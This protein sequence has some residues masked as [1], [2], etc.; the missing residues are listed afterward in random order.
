MKRNILAAATLAASLFG[1][2]AFA[3]ATIHTGSQVKPGNYVL[4]PSHTRVLFSTT[5][6][7]FTT[8]YGEFTNTTGTLKLD[9]INPAA[10]A[11]SV[12]IRTNSVSTSNT[13][14]DGELVEWFDATTYPTIAF[15]STSVAPTGPNTADVTGNLTFHGVTK[16]VTLSVSFNGAGTNPMDK[17]YTA[18]FEVSGDLKRADFGVTKDEPFIGDDVKLI[19]SAAFEHE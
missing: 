10:S 12:V 1:S 8:W 9:P 13:R 18:G 2:Q 7:G 4:E 11:L 6:L 17:K 14:L 19:I 3:Q 5:H 15:V 16:P